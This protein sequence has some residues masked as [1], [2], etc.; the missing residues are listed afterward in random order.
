MKE[1]REVPSR[2]KSN[3]FRSEITESKQEE[4]DPHQNLT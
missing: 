2:T 1:K 3:A 4:K